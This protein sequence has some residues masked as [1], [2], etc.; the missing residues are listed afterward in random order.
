MLFCCGGL[1]QG[2]IRGV[3]GS[4]LKTSSA[5]YG[6]RFLGRSGAAGV[7]PVRFSPSKRLHKN[8][9]RVGGR[10]GV[11]SRPRPPSRLR[12]PAPPAV[13]RSREAEPDPPAVR[14]PAAPPGPGTRPC[15]RRRQRLG[16]QLET[17]RSPLAG[18]WA[19]ADAEP[20]G[21]HLLGS[22]RREK[23]LFL[24]LHKQFS[25]CEQSQGPSPCRRNTCRFG[26]ADLCGCPPQ[27]GLPSGTLS[28]AGLRGPRAPLATARRS[29]KSK[30]F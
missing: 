28:S 17:P 10:R 8:P 27:P 29:L 14:G 12:P 19:T 22:P 25:G 11:R 30:I 24:L 9:T 3:S 6:P 26:Q 7:S 23:S 1:C 21:R 15:R 16:V 2:L 18:T 4:A 20:E 13:S 5:A